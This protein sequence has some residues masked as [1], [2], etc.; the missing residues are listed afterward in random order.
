[1]RE[2][3]EEE[4]LELESE[5]WERED[6]SNLS[7]I[8]EG[9]HLFEN[10]SRKNQRDINYREMLAYL[11]LQQGEDMKLRQHAYEK[12]LR[13]I[14]RVVRLDTD[15]ARAYYRLGFLYFYKEAW[16]LSI[17][18]FQQAL[19]CRPLASRNRLE[20]EQEMKA[21]HYIMKGAQMILNESLQKVSTIPSSD[22]ELFGEIKL[23]MEELKEGLG[24]REKP[25]V[26]TVNG[27]EQRY[28]TEK[29]Y[30]ELSDPYE[31]ENC[32][33]FNQLHIQNTL[34]LLNDQ[35]IQ[36]T[37]KYVT[38]LELIM[39]HPEGISVEAILQRKFRNSK[40]PQN[41]LR[42]AI[43]RLRQRLEPID[44]HRELIQTVD[45]GYKWNCQ[46]EYRMFKHT[47]DV[48]SDLLLD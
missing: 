44:P 31:N 20:K 37:P 6:E 45:G 30:E 7:W 36:I 23:L 18:S 4:L 15:N 35:D 3:S 48:S 28:L 47:R 9:V 29:E 5:W 22:L 2:L 21:H 42:R 1:M 41:N 24:E 39:Q 34:I 40:N 14:Q 43:G 25:Y 13:V 38:L 11:L 33:I 26:L 8:N 27:K 12:A 46:R 16:A 32:L 10:L 17:D 19:N